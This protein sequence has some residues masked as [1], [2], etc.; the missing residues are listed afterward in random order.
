VETRRPLKSRIDN[1]TREANSLGDRN[2]FDHRKVEVRISRPAKDAAAD[3]A[4]PA[5]ERDGR[6]EQRT[7]RPGVNARVFRRPVAFVIAAAVGE[8]RPRAQTGALPVD[9]VHK[10]RERVTGLRL[11]NAG[12]RP[13]ADDAVEKAVRRAEGQL[14]NEIEHEAVPRVEARIAALGPETAGEPGR[15]AR[16]RAVAGARHERIGR[17]VDRMAPGVEAL[18]LAETETPVRQRLRHPDL[19]RV[20]AR[21]AVRKN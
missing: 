18:N 6:G 12:E 4:L 8:S 10:D 11:V 13:V 21:N 14:V 1:R 2:A 3:V 9:A 15:I 19:H 5:V 16:Q 7:V 17:V 20:V